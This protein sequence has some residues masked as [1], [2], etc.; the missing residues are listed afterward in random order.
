MALR[1]YR[2]KPATRDQ[3]RQ[4]AIPAPRLI[5]ERVISTWDEISWSSKLLVA[6]LVGAYLWKPC[7]WLINGTTWHICPNHVAEDS[8]MNGMTTWPWYQGFGRN[9]LL[10]PL[11]TTSVSIHVASSSIHSSLVW[12]MNWLNSYMVWCYP[13]PSAVCILFHSN[14]IIGWLRHGLGR[15]YDLLVI[16]NSGLL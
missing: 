8:Q 10:H 6:I 4:K 2:M 5:C 12:D 15:H 1:W 16:V 11:T 3:I 7:W 9:D 13:H 14:R